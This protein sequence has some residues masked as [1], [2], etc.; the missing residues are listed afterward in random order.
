MARIKGK[1]TKPE[2]LVRRALHASGLRYRLHDKRLPGKPDLV[3]SACKTALF[4]NG[5]FF[6]QHP[7]CRHARMP[8]SRLE[9]W[10]N[11]LAGN[12]ERDH[13]NWRMLN[14]AGW[15]FMVIWEC[16][17]KNRENFKGRI[18]DLIQLLHRTRDKTPKN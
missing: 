1:D 2:M 4:V 13:R 12:V 11:K 7:G 17:T 18:K 8:K 5:C 14:E 10:Q 15:K 6:H 9:F 16:E 3:F